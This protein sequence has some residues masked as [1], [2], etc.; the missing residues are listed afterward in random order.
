MRQT[1][2][3]PSWHVSRAQALSYLRQRYG[4]TPPPLPD[5]LYPINND[6]STSVR[7]REDL[8]YDGAF[9]QIEVI[10][11]ALGSDEIPVRDPQGVVVDGLAV[12]EWYAIETADGPWHAGT[13]SNLTNQ[14]SADLSNDDGQ[15][16]SRL[17]PIPVDST[18]FSYS[19]GTLV[20]GVN[21]NYVRGCWQATTPSIRIRVAD[22][23]FEDNSGSISWRLYKA[24]PCDFVER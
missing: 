18:D 6:G 17:N 8:R 5:T 15:S 24:Y 3:W 10:G 4:A 22:S 11:E 14:Y 23:M 1:Q 12:G 2:G 16:W 9:N 19:W 20:E 7:Y 21:E 13:N